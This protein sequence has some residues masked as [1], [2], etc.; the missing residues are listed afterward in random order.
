MYPSYRGECTVSFIYKSTQFI[1]FVLHSTELYT[2]MK[3]V[4]FY[5]LITE[6]RII[7]TEV[8]VTYYN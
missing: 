3:L 5:D 6:Y 2:F 4:G 1:I 8:T 7:N